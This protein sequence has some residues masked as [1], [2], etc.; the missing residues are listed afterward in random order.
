MMELWDRPILNLF[1]LF[2]GLDLP[3]SARDFSFQI[4]KEF[5]CQVGKSRNIF[6]LPGKPFNERHDHK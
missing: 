3:E 4:G 6:T 5:E 2:F 1:P